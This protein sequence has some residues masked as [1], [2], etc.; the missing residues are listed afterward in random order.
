MKPHTDRSQRSCCLRWVSG[1]WYFDVT[2]IPIV[3]SF[4]PSVLRT[5]LKG[6]PAS[7]R[8]YQ[9]DYHS[10]IIESNSRRFHWLICNKNQLCVNLLNGWT[11]YIGK[12]QRHLSEHSGVDS[13]SCIMFILVSCVKYCIYCEILSIYLVIFMRF[14]EQML[15]SPL[16]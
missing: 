6:S 5:L 14:C 16:R 9:V 8:R 3:T 10:L 7:S 4:W 2:Q 1:L 12:C 15:Q 13:N 11:F